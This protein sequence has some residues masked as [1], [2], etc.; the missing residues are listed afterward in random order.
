VLQ[1]VAVCCSVLQCVAVRISVHPRASA[2]VCYSVCVAVCVCCS[3]CIAVCC[4]LLQWVTVHVEAKRVHVYICERRYVWI[5]I[6]GCWYKHVRVKMY[7]CAAAQ[8]SVLMKVA[9][10]TC[11]WLMCIYTDRTRN[12]RVF[13]LAKQSNS[14]LQCLVSHT[15]TLALSLTHTEIWRLHTMCIH[16]RT[17]WYV[18]THM[19]GF[20]VR[21]WHVYLEFVFDTYSLCT[22]MSGFWYIWV[23]LWHVYIYTCICMWILICVGSF[24]TCM[25]IH[26]TMYAYICMHREKKKKRNS[27]AVVRYSI[28]RFIAHEWIRVW[29]GYD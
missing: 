26:R 28:S 4:R 24:V 18:C 14:S 23:R 8:D 9:V 16:M 17:K 7:E 22:H 29:G 20:W 15:H 25:Y 12:T 10:Y 1:C 11:T 19:S 2:W 6:S 21:V 27:F 13:P 5:Y 3:V